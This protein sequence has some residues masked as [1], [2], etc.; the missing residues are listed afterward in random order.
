[1]MALLMLLLRQKKLDSIKVRES[2]TPS[3][4]NFDPVFNKHSHENL[5]PLRNTMLMSDVSLHSV[6]KK[7]KE[8]KKEERKR[9][10]REEAE[11]EEDFVVVTQRFEPMQST[12]QGYIRAKKKKKKKKMKKIMYRDF[13]TVEFIRFVYFRLSVF[14]EHAVMNTID[15]NH[16]KIE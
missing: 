15:R 1:M 16:F 11:E 14:S 4:T 3:S 6:N 8:R 10:R 5:R 13:A 9:E 7:T 12:T 2:G